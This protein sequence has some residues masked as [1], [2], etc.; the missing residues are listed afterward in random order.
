[1]R[2]HACFDTSEQAD[3]WIRNSEGKNV[4]THDLFVVRTCE[5]ISADLLLQPDTKFDKENYRHDELDRIM[6]FHREDPHA[7]QISSSGAKNMAVRRKNEK[8]KSLSVLTKSLHTCNE[9]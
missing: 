4:R 6:R 1:M 5:W 8:K 9:S 2:V 7:S 3:A